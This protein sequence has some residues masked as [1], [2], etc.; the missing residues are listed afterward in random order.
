MA[1]GRVADFGD[2]QN[3]LHFSCYD[4]RHAQ[5]CSKWAWKKVR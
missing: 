2:D 1:L 3:S 5:T 4:I